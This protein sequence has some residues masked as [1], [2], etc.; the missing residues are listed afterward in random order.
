MVEMIACITFTHACMR[1][2]KTLTF[3]V[4]KR[5]EEGEYVQFNYVILF[6]FFLFVPSTTL[7]FDNHHLPQTSTSADDVC[8]D[9]N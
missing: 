7:N 3:I 2:V 4:S 1:N 8:T 9:K 5:C 6:F